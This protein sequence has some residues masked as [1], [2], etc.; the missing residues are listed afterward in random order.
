MIRSN[1]FSAGTFDSQSLSRNVIC[2][3]NP[4]ES[5]LLW[6]KAKASGSRSIAVIS[7]DTPAF[8]SAKTIAPEPVP[9]SK[10]RS[11]P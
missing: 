1:C 5:A 9:N 6:A 4:N 8:T 7:A 2:S 10:T 11:A 3:D